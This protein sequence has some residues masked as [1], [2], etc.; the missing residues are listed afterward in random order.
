[1]LGRRIRF[2]GLTVSGLPADTAGSVKVLKVLGFDI[3]LGDCTDEP[4]P[5]VRPIDT[6]LCTIGDF[7]FV[8]GRT[9]GASVG[10][11]MR[12]C[13][14]IPTSCCMLSVI[15]WPS[16]EYSEDAYPALLLGW[17]ARSGLF[18]LKPSLGISSAAMGSNIWTFANAF[19]PL[20]RFNLGVARFPL[21]GLV[22]EGS[23]GEIEGP[24]GGALL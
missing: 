6:C 24:F 21:M 9:G 2:N 13:A 4:D 5:G 12:D 17:N 23:S 11:D 3:V 19:V 7:P 15:S 22:F 14:E 1:M 18:S 20:L 10:D 16:L 8:I